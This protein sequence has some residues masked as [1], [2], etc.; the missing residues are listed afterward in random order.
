MPGTVGR[1]TEHENKLEVVKYDVMENVIYLGQEWTAV[2][3][4][5]KPEG[6]YLASGPRNFETYV[7][8]KHSEVYD[9]YI[10]RH[11][12]KHDIEV[13]G[14]HERDYHSEGVSM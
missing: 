5:P 13:I 3:R 7:G 1:G 6:A 4:A 8:S 10:P 2:V 9:C 12:K 14:L 11:E